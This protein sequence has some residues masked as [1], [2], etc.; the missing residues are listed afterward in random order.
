M[1]LSSYEVLWPCFTAWGREEISIKYR[2][3]IWGQQHTWT[4]ECG[5][6]LIICWC[7]VND[8][9]H[10]QIFFSA[11]NGEKQHVYVRE[12]QGNKELE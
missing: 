3:F 5:S 11:H 1:L 7:E 12:L 6:V 2:Y 10:M 9:E 4:L 8:S